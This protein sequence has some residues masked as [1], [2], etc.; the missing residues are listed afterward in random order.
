MSIRRLRLGYAFGFGIGVFFVALG[1]YAIIFYF[2]VNQAVSYSLYGNY[3][4]AGIMSIF[5]GA[6]IIRVTYPVFI[7]LK[8]L[9]VRTC[10]QC[11]AV[12]EETADYCH[13]CSRNLNFQ[14]K[15]Y[16]PS[17]DEETTG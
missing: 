16:E 17:L 4:F 3:A 14:L 11:H 5:L 12:N 7:P 8:I 10:P 1:V 9:S 15:S 6:N 2:T 13:K